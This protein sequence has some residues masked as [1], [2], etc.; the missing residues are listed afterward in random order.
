[1][2]R[3]DLGQSVKCPRR[4]KRRMRRT[5]L[6]PTSRDRR[7]GA[8]RGAKSTMTGACFYQKPKAHK[9]KESAVGSVGGT[10]IRVQGP[11]A[12]TAT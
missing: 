8:E 7:A 10:E 2:L 3:N 6:G 12:D 11:F 5:A 1:M 9:A 4:A